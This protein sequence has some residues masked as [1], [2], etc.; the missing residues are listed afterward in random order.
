MRGEPRIGEDDTS[1]GSHEGGKWLWRR[2]RSSSKGRGLG[3]RREE[4]EEGAETGTREAPRKVE[5]ESLRERG[6]QKE[7]KK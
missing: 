3:F 2:R 4:E 1:E 7:R 5:E 6:R